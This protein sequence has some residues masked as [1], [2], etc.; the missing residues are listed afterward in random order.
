MGTST[1]AA[2]EPGPRAGRRQNR[3]IMRFALA[4][5]SLAE[6]FAIDVDTKATRG[7]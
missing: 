7:A 5:S 6:A 3:G 1:S 2:K 4:H